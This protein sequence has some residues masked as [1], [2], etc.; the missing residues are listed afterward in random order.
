[1]GRRNLGVKRDSNRNRENGQREDCL[2]KPKFQFSFYFLNKNNLLPNN[3]SQPKRKRQIK[4]AS[5]GNSTTRERLSDFVRTSK[6]GSLGLGS[7]NK[8]QVSKSTKEYWTSM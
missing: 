5:A 7:N 4:N 8:Y 1:M 2:G 3:H 6:E